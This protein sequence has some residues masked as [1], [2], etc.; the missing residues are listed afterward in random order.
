MVEASQLQK[1][2]EALE[3]QEQA[4]ELVRPPYSQY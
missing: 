2:I 3:R 4:D 1:R